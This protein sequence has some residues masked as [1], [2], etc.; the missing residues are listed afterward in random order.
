MNENMPGFLKAFFGGVIALATFLWGVPDVWLYTLLA[1][2]ALDYITGV[3]GAALSHT[4]SSAVG[5]KGILK[6]MLFLIVV[7]V[8]H[9]IDNAMAAGGVLRTAVIGFLLANEGI[10]IL[11]NCA[12]CGLPVPKKLIAVLEQLKGKHE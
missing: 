5:F 1:F 10:S 7:A 3:I 11:E 12:R 4:L 9:L 6:K 2:I 8:A